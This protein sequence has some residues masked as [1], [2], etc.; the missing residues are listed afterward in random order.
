M[1]IL[2]LCNDYAGSKVHCEL[3]KNLDHL[4]IQQTVYCPVREER[5][6]GL[7]KF[8]SNNT[9]FIYSYCIKSWYKY[10]YHYKAHILYHDLKKHVNIDNYDLINATTMFSDGA[11]AYKAYKEYGIPYTV[12]VRNGDINDFIGF[13]KHTYLTGRKIALHASKIFFISPGTKA[14]FENTSFAK[15]ILDKIQSKMIVQP[16]GI[17]E[18]WLNNI[19]NQNH[20]GHDILYIGDFSSNKNVVRL[21]EAITMLRKSSIF[22]D[23]KLIIVGGDVPGG[24][25]NN[26]GKTQKMIDEHPDFIKSLGKIYNKDKLREI[27]AQCAMFAM[28]SIHETFGLVYVEALSQNLPVV[29]TKRQG[30]DGV[31]DDTIGIKVNPLSVDEIYNAILNILKNPEKYNNKNVNFEEFD[32]KN[33]SNHYYQY[34][35]ELIPNSQN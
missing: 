33:I 28:P 27:M 21:G 6:L 25:R 15:P 19:T 17:N 5:L 29:Y 26:D 22:N 1:K 30:I 4:N 7:N 35:K 20:S 2:H 18:Y 12:T 10:V 11:L 23:A 14:L 3:I 34:F 13:M 16:N 8:D 9:N 24:G 31:F 32:W